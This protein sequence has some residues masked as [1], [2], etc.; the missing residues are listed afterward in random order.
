MDDRT[1]TTI[2]TGLLISTTAAMAWLSGLP[3]LFPSLGPSA[4]V[5][6]MFQDS[7]ATSPRRVIGG[8][9]IGVVAGLFAY[10]LLASGISMT[11]TTAPGSLEGLRLAA[12]GVLATTLTAGGMLAT[13]TRHPPAC[14]TT[15]IVSLGLLSTLLEGALIVL[16]VAVL[17]VAHRLLLATERVGTRYGKQFLS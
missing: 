13:D 15:L 6:A 7:E 10:H 8:H 1:G 5:L 11:A 4:F 3:M 9:A 12:S 16:A 14:A 2:H 17:L